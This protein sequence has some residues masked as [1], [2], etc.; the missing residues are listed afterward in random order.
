MELD[1]RL[2][3]WAGDEGDTGK[4]EKAAE[5]EEPVGEPSELRW[6]LLAEGVERG[7]DGRELGA[8]DGSAGPEGDTGPAAIEE[9]EAAEEA[10]AEE[11]EPTGEGWYCCAL[12]IERREGALA[13]LTLAAAVS[14]LAAVCG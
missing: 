12:L 4:A 2:A 1:C 11:E 5:A 8:V 13:T 6:P 9:G 3:D 14:L 7:R 10:E